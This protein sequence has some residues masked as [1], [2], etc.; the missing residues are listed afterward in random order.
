MPP[1]TGFAT[2]VVR[3]ADCWRSLNPA[4][5]RASTETAAILRIVGDRDLAWDYETTPLG[6]NPYGSEAWWNLAKSLAAAGDADL[7]D[8][9]FA[10]AFDAEPTNPQILWEQADNLRRLGRGPAADG[11]VRRIAEGSWQPRFQGLANQA[12]ARAV[13]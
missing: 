5:E 3:A 2:K 12:K 11:L 1:P 9:A 13:R 10:A 6:R 8:S 7:A 4:A